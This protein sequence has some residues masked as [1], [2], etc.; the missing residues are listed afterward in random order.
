MAESNLMRKFRGLQA[1][2]KRFCE[3]K[4]TKGYV[5]AK[6]NEYVKAA[7]AKGQTKT[8]AQQKANRVLTGGC[9]MSASIRK[10]KSKKR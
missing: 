6:A 8:E 3:G 10:A 9:K 2:K 7:V 4:Q 5:K 1:A